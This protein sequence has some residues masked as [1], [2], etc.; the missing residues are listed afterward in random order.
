MQPIIVDASEIRE[1]IGYTVDVSATVPLDTVDV[2]GVAYVPTKH[3]DIIG[4]L[5]NSGEGL[6]LH[7][8]VRAS[9]QVDC[10]R[11][12]ASVPFDVATD[13]DTL[14]V[15]RT[16]ETAGEA[17]E[18]DVIPFDGDRIDIAP[19]VISALRVEL[20]LAP[21]CDEECAGICPDCGT[22]LNTGG[23][24][25][26]EKPSEDSPFAALKDLLPDEPDQS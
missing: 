8:N 13:I 22:D 3:A 18:Q 25:C 21:L 26:S 15:R 10:S 7:G 6:V 23:C 14:F 1:A 20:P 4:T 16:P 9:F 12:L 5:T 19:V 11:C 24:D 17:D 2:S